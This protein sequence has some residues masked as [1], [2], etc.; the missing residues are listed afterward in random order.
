MSKWQQHF[1]QHRPLAAAARQ[2]FPGISVINK[3]GRNPTIDS[4]TAPESL[5]DFGGLYPFQAS[6][7][8]LECLSAST[9]DDSVG[10]GMRTIQIEGLDANWNLQAQVATMDGTSVVAVAGTWRRVFRILGLTSGTLDTNDGDITVRLASAGATQGMMIADTGQS[11]LGIYTVPAGKVAYVLDY[12]A[13]IIAVL[14]A[15]EVQVALMS[16]END[17]AGRPFRQRHLLGI[18]GAGTSSNIHKFEIPIVLPE[19]T[20][21]ELRLV[22]VTA[23]TGT[24][25]AG[26]FDLVIEDQ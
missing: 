7:F 19:K 24:G 6:S 3:F 13:N 15:N 21:I 20:D 14:T 26:S 4:A 1:L 16:R 12:G 25:V 5:T 23:A 17:I 9:N 2:K 8:S 18:T 10:T 11:A 22:S